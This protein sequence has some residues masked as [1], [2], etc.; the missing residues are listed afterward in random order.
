MSSNHSSCATLSHCFSIKIILQQ[1]CT[2]VLVTGGGYILCR[3][4]PQYTCTT[5]NLHLGEQ[6]STTDSK[7]YH[8]LPERD[9]TVSHIK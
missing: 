9:N 5:S 8:L 1:P 6:L 7:F 3:F 2:S 4:T